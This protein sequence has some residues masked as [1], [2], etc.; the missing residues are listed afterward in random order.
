MYF[1]ALVLFIILRFKLTPAITGCVIISA[2]VVFCVL[3][4]MQNSYHWR[5]E[6]NRAAERL[7]VYD[8]PPV[9]QDG[10]KELGRELS[11]LV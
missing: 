10:G 11:T 1:S 7:P 2:G 6:N 5:L 3:S 8:L 9:R 4:V